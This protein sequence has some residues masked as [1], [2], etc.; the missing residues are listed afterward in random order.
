MNHSY[1]VLD[2]KVGDTYKDGSKLKKLYLN[3]I[4][5]KRG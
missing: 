1:L 2:K 5:A 3:L 4:I